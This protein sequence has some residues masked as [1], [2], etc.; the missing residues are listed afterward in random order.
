MARTPRRRRAAAADA[1][2]ARR[3]MPRSG[4][5][6]QEGRQERGAVGQAGDAEPAGVRGVGHSMELA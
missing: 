4:E 3:H 2:V 1:A 5:G 6:A